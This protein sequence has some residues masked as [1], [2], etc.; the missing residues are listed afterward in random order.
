MKVLVTGGCGFVGRHVVREILEQTDWKVVA[1]DRDPVRP[2][3]ESTKLRIVQDDLSVGFMS[4]PWCENVDAVINLA[5]SSDV[6]SFLENPAHHTMNNVASTLNL[7]EWA[8]HQELKAFIQVSTNEVYG[9]SWA[10]TSLTQEWDALIPQTPYSASKACQEMLA[11]GWRQTYDVPVAI[12]N[13]MHVFGE[14]QPAARFIPK[15]I[16]SILDGKSVT[17]YHRKAPTYNPNGVMYGAQVRNWTYVG[18]LARALIWMLRNDPNETDVDVFGRLDRWNVAGPEESCLTIAR[19]LGI[20][21][22]HD[23]TIEWVS[24]S[25]RPGHDFRYALDGSKIKEAGFTEPY[26]LKMG[27]QRTINWVLN[28]RKKL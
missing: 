23:F 21:L 22:E 7:L 17:I 4:S 6:P 1:L 13:T 11:I 24:E 14:G 15:T 25:L 27:L 28:E 18:D 3:F 16:N 2:P 10:S 8:R 5:A 12:V 19:L 26:G 9:P 20:M